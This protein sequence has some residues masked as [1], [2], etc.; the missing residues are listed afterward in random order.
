[1]KDKKVWESSSAETQHTSR[2]LLLDAK[3]DGNQA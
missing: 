3:K 1:M 2:L